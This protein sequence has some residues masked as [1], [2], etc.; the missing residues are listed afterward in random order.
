M[1]ITIFTPLVAPHGRA[2]LRTLFFLALV[3]AAVGSDNARD[4]IGQGAADLAAQRFEGALKKFTA[5]VKANPADPQAMFF[6]GV[7]LNRLGRYAEALARLQHAAKMGSKHPDLEF[8]LGWALVALRRPKEAVSYLEQFEREHPGRG[9]TSEFLGRAYFG[10][11]EFDKAEDAFNEALR[12]DP[13]L[14]PTVSLG[15]ALIAQERDQ[16][17]AVH[18]HLQTVLQET[19]ESPVSRAL[20]SRVDRLSRLAALP[21]AMETAWG[22][23]LSTAGGYND[24]VTGVGD[25]ALLPSEITG[26]GSPFARFNF[27]GNY[28]W[29]TAPDNTFSL[30]YSFLADVYSKVPQLDLRDHLWQAEYTRTFTANLA[31]TLRLSDEFA[32]LG[33][34]NFR[35]QTTVRPALVVRWNDWTV[36]E[37]AY[38]FTFADYYFPAPPVLDRDSDTHTVLFTQYLTPSHGRVQ[39]RAGYF[40]TWNNADGADFDYRTHG[41]FGAAS[42]SLFW[43]LT[44]DAAYI[45]NFD[46]YANA[47]SL[48]GLNSSAITGGFEFKRADDV[49]TVTVRLSRPLTKRLRAYAQY[50]FNNADSNIRFFNYDQHVWSGG[51]V[52]QF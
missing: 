21:Q 13:T 11:R 50:D 2:L 19:P 38:S 47:N 1:K 20:R 25:T 48:A 41:V 22:L 6:Q 7:A 43:K 5:A 30:A 40:H 52:M 46:R 26:K 23:S 18:R 28:G 31:A 14:K 34:D 37:A 24:N 35:N 3:V 49:D 44:A 4:L 33:G 45:H 39:L 8:E 16:H 10:L 12:R 27:S 29:R 15:L 9:Q 36:S 32:Q 51:L 42:V 17:D